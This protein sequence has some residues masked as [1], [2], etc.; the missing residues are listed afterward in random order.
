MRREEFLEKFDHW[1]EKTGEARLIREADSPGPESW[2]EYYGS[3]R[4]TD[5]L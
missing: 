3:I 5:S 2:Y 4:E 1:Y